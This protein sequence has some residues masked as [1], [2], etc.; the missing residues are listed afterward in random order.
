MA[1]GD[2]GAGQSRVRLRSSAAPR[3][4][5]SD[6]LAG[7]HQAARTLAMPRATSAPTILLFDSGLG[8]LTVYREVVRACPDARFVYAADD[9]M[10]P[11]GAVEESRL[12]A[13]IVAM[14]G[15][16]IAEHRPELVVIAC[17][18]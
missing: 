7:T 11:Y 8:G 17:N 14:L 9:A 10:F 12:V 3:I 4:P 5:R 15:D 6:L 13:R 16:L 1:I 2:R 18:T